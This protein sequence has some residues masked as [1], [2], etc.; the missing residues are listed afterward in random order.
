MNLMIHLLM[1]I[2]RNLLMRNSTFRECLR[3]TGLSGYWKVFKNILRA[4][5]NDLTGT[6]ETQESRLV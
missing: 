3:K 2:M 5:A 1:N 6:E 4:V